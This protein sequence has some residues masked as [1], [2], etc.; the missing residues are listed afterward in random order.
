QQAARRPRVIADHLGVHAEARAARQVAVVRVL[1]ALLRR[2]GRR[3]TVGRR[4]HD[5]LEELLDVPAAL[6]ELDRQPVEQL[7]VTGRLA[8]GAEVA[9]RAYQAGAEHFL[10]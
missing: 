6:A 4:R 7:G 5:Q 8:A 10:P 1:L 9:G 3:L 2:R